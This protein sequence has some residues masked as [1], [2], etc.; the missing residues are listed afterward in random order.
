MKR[1]SNGK[2]NVK[3]C[4]SRRDFYKYN[5]KRSRIRWFTTIYNNYTDRQTDR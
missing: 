3:F 1:G 5:N 2:Y 4:T